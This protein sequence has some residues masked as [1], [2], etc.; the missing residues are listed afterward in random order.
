MINTGKQRSGSWWP[1]KYG[2]TGNE[3]GITCMILNN[4]V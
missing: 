2:F 3:G 1:E 4:R